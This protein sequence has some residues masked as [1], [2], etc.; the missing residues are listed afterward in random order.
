MGGG[1]GGVVVITISIAVA[2]TMV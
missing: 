1:I 2:V